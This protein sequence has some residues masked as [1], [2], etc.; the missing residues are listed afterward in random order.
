LIKSLGWSVGEWSSLRPL[1]VNLGGVAVDNAE[2]NHIEVTPPPGLRLAGIALM[3]VS[4]DDETSEDPGVGCVL[5]TARNDPYLAHIRW[6]PLTSS[7]VGPPP[8]S[9]KVAVDL[10]LEAGPQMLQGL[11]SSIFIVLILLGGVV[12]H[13]G[14]LRSWWTNPLPT[15]QIATAVLVV[16]PVAL[17]LAGLA[18]EHGLVRRR[19]APVRWQLIL[20]GFLAFAAAVSLSVDPFPTGHRFLLWWLLLVLGVGNMAYGFGLWAMSNQCRGRPRQACPEVASPSV[21]TAKEVGT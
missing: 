2:T 4:S 21:P 7:V 16:V 10:W 14:V 12:I 3:N 1:T 15:S 17:A 5:A 11:L 8:R 18:Q 9:V 6:P 20:N 13:V 19:L